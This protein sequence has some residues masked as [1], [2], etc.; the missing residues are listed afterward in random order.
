M[1]VD[2]L[3]T[4]NGDIADFPEVSANQTFTLGDKEP[5]I[6]HCF[7]LDPANPKTPIDTR[8]RKLQRL[9]YLHHPQTQLHLEVLSTEPAFQFYT[10]KFVDVAATDKNPSLGPRCGICIEPSRYVNAVNVP[11][12][13]EQVV[14][15]KGQTYGAR[16]VYKGWKS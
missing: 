7:I 10:G 3:A 1:V 2:D 6:D 14:L 16:N 12:W 5:D 4:P 11:A 9:A 15:R 8:G 13:R